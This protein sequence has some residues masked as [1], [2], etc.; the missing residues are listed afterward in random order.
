MSIGETVRTR[1]HRVWAEQLLETWR[2][3]ERQLGD[4]FTT[5]NR[6]REA[7]VEVVTAWMSYQCAMSSAPDELILVADDERQFVAVSASA[8]PLLGYEP[9]E[10]CGRR[11]DDLVAQVEAKTVPDRWVQFRAA[12]READ[13]IPLCT[14]SGTVVLFEYEARP[15]FPVPGCHVS[16]LKIAGRAAVAPSSS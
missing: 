5:G 9:D 2:R 16:R 11:V 15:D 8:R 7:V 6:V 1:N 3:A 10:L 4:A 13:M 14:K 12:R